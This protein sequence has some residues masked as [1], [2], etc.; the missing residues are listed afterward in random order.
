MVIAGDLR[1][2]IPPG[3]ADSMGLDRMAGVLLQRDIAASRSQ[4]TAQ[5][6]EEKDSRLASFAR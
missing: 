5:S 2:T 4:L 1:T 3:I 6:M